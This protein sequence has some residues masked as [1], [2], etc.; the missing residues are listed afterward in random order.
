MGVTARSSVRQRCPRKP[1]AEGVPASPC[2]RPLSPAGCAERYRNLL[3]QASEGVF[4]TDMEG[5]CL[6]ANPAGAQLLGYEVEELVGRGLL[7]HIA[8]VSPAGLADALRDLKEGRTVRIGKSFRR[9]NGSEFPGEL[10][11]RCLSD[12]TVQSILR[13]VTERR[14]AEAAALTAEGRLRDIFENSPIGVFFVCVAPDGRFI[15]ETINPHGERAFG[16]DRWRSTGMAIDELFP[17]ERIARVEAFFRRCVESGAPV[18]CEIEVVREAEAR[19][20]HAL[21]VPLRDADGVVRHIAGF[22]HD[23]TGQRRAEAALRESEERFSKIFHASPGAIA[24]SDFE[25]G[26]VLEAND[27]FLRIFGQTREQVRGRTTVG[28]GVWPDAQARDRFLEAMRQHGA[29]RDFEMRWNTPGGERFCLLTA[30]R[31]ELH[32]RA[33]I[34]SLVDDVTGLRRA[35]S[36]RTEAAEREQ[37]AAESFTRRLI[38][39][40]EAER[41]RI[42]GELHDSL[43][44]ELLLITNRLQ[45]AL[46]NPSLPQ[47]LRKDFQDIGA[48]A[49][50]AVAEVRRIS[51]ALRPPQLDHLGLTRALRAMLDSVAPT[52]GFEL[53]HH[54]DDIDGAYPSEME[55][56]WYRI[57][58][59]SL[60]NILKHA[61]ARHVEVLLE[62]DIRDVR[63]IVA[64][65]GCGIPPEPAASDGLGLRN[66]AERV[67]ILGGRLRIDSAPGTGT[68]LEVTAPLPAET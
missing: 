3:E 22:V 5:R 68:R 24:V 46:A 15:A 59:E 31:I 49:T 47:A 48:L 53:C 25:T 10:T 62:R 27:S 43:G 50:Q 11:G 12:G 30:E 61:R 41:R 23:I 7:E 2:V 38:E 17:A 55:T 57:L 9:K 42:A 56:N 66:I 1:S 33:C 29:V 63:L 14:R 18:D 37:R 51:H 44:Q 36:E 45:L 67:R 64:D 58:Q 4:I 39:S 52:A 8:A 6:L 35:E 20:V 19:L 40:Q 13:D 54:L 65:D 28:I 26:S 60:N 34:L 32:G 16:V 21:L